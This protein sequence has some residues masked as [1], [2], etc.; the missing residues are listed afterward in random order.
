MRTELPYKLKY[1]KCMVCGKHETT[2]RDIT[3]PVVKK[4]NIGCQDCH[5][6]VP[7]SLYAEMHSCYFAMVEKRFQWDKLHFRIDADW[8]T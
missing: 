5:T 1:F 2:E 3:V 7:V 8:H 4:I 6:V